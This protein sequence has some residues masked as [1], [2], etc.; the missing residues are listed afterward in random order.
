MIK[1]F[2][3]YNQY[4]TKVERH[5]FFDLVSLGEGN[6]TLEFNADEI[7]FLGEKLECYVDTRFNNKR[8]QD[9][10]V[11]ISVDKVSYWRGPLDSVIMKLPDEWY[12]VDFFTP[13]HKYYKCD[14]IEGVVKCLNEC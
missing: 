7:N 14:Q 2:E 11:Y 8:K 5:E 10:H 4:Y 1:L 6:R 13:T 12:L 9:S 3:E